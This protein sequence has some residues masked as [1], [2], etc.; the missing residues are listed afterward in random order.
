[1]LAG[2]IAC[3]SKNRAKVRKFCKVRTRRHFY[4]RNPKFF[5]NRR[6]YLKDKE[7]IALG[8]RTQ[9]RREATNIKMPLCKVSKNRFFCFFGMGWIIFMYIQKLQFLVVFQIPE[10]S[11]GDRMINIKNYIPLKNTIFFK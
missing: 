10:N 6:A 5:Y 1:V 8:V 4:I 3:L 2:F 9:S 11:K 7:T